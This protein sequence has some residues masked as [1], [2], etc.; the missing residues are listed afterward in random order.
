MNINLPPLEAKVRLSFMNQHDP[1]FAGKTVD[2][3]IFAVASI[4]GQTPLF[5]FVCPDG[6]IWW[7]MPIHAFCWKDEAPERELSDL[8]LWDSFSYQITVFTADLLKNKRISV[9]KRDRGVE[10]GV[11]LFT[12]DWFGG[13]FSEVPGQHKSGHVIKLDDGN[14]AIQPNNRIRL[15]DPNFTT[16][17]TPIPR[18]IANTLY[19]SESTSKWQTENSEVYAYQTLQPE[20]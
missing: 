11:Y 19:T 7:R 20:R 9:T 3:Q 4:P 8:V 1:E 16:D 15:F 12:L 17:S 14:F 5:H 13:G 2:C 6:G 10:E 18:K